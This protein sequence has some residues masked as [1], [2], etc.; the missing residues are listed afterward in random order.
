MSPRRPNG[1]KGVEGSRRTR[2]AKVGSVVAA[3]LRARIHDGEWAVG[4]AL[5]GEYDLASEYSVA[6]G[7]IRAVVQELAS[8]GLVVTRHGAGTYVTAFA[9]ALESNLVELTSMTDTIRDARMDAHMRYTSR[10]LLPATDAVR[11]RLGLPGPEPLTVFSTS[12]Q[13]EADGRMVAVSF[14]TLRADLLPPGFDV[15]GIEGS[16]FSLWAEMGHPIRYAT[17]EVHA[18]VG[19]DIGLTGASAGESFVGL[20]QLHFDGANTPVFYARTYFREGYFTFSLM[21]VRSEDA[22]RATV[23][24]GDQNE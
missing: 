18:A 24:Q 6:R 23:R 2:S 16:L 21:R 13:V 1:P 15:Q 19:A 4:A 17:T 3:D 10:E 22:A 9:G 14:E 7:T 5:P 11:Q 20:Y 8:Q 12:R